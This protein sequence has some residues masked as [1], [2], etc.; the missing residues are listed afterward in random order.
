MAHLL[1]LGAATY[2]GV[3]AARRVHTAYGQT[4]EEMY[5]R[6]GNPN[7]Y[8]QPYSNYPPE[9]SYPQYSAAPYHH[10]SYH[11]QSYNYR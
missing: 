5:T 11:G 7:Y 2:L 3:V 8:N 10:S 1:A 4:K 6:Q 9:Q